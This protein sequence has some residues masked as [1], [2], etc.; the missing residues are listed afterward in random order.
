MSNFFSSFKAASFNFALN[1]EREASLIIKNIIS[2]S[3]YKLP[4]REK[5]FLTIMYRI[6]DG[7]RLEDI[8]LKLY[9]NS[10]YHWTILYINDRYDYVTD[11][12]MEDSKVLDYVYKK[13]G[14]GADSETHHYEDGNGNWVGVTYTD[15]NKTTAEK[16][17]L[18]VPITNYEFEISVNDAKRFIKVIRPEYIA[19]FAAKFED[20]IRNG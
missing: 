4:E 13:Y 18:S 10:N 12:P 9:G 6:Q 7:E 19:D 14:Y 16:T 3:N 17:E 8:A 5:D 15:H 20:S 1:N 11:Y 2:R